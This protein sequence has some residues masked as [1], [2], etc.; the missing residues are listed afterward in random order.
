MGCWLLPWEGHVLAA[1]ARGKDGLCQPSPVR[2]D[3]VQH[4][5]EVIDSEKALASP[6]TPCTSPLAPDHCP[7]STPGLLPPEVW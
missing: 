7:A 1:R 6:C 4:E 2:L 5:G 3:Q